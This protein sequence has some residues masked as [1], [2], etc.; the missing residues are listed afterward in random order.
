[1]EGAFWGGQK[2]PFLRR[3]PFGVV[4]K[5]P[6]YGGCLWVVKK[7]PIGFSHTFGRRAFFALI[8][9]ARIFCISIHVEGVDEGKRRGQN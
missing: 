3:V 8:N 5:A 6:S 1:M 4:K 9:R 7:A 2:S